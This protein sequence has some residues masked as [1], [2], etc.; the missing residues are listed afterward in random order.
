MPGGNN[1]RAQPTMNHHE[2]YA[3]LSKLPRLGTLDG[4]SCVSVRSSSS[5]LEP[6]EFKQVS[7]SFTQRS[8]KQPRQ[9]VCEPIRKSPSKPECAT[10]VTNHIST[11][12]WDQFDCF[13]SSV[14]CG[15][16]EA[17]FQ[18]KRRLKAKFQYLY[19]DVLRQERAP[20]LHEVYTELY[21]IESD[22][23]KTNKEHEVRQMEILSR[24][25]TTVEMA[26]KCNDIFSSSHRSGKAIHSVLTKGVAGIGKT[27]SV[28]KFVLDWADGR[29][30]QDIE[31]IYPLA[32]RELNLIKE[33]QFSLVELLQYFRMEIPERRDFQDHNVLFIFD[34]LD[35]CRFALDFQNN[36]R[37]LSATM[38]VSL[39]VLLTNLIG[40][41]L[42]P[43]G[44]LWIT[45][46]P[47]AANQI[48]SQFVDLVTEV[49]GFNDLQKEE[50]LKKRISDQSL[51][52]RIIT[53]VKASRCLFI[54]CQIPVFSWITAT[55]LEIMIG[56]SEGGDIPK[57]LTQ[58]YIHF[59]LIQARAKKR[60]FDRKKGLADEDVILK[61]GKLAFEQLEKGNIIFYE[62][63]LRACGI[64]VKE[65]VVYSGVCSQIFKEECALTQ[66]KV[67]CFLHLSI[68]EFLAAL[69]VFVMC[70]VNNLNVLDGKTCFA[71]DR[72]G[73]ALSDLHRSAVDRALKSENGNMDLV[74][75]FL[76]GLSVDSNQTLLQ[77]LLTQVRHSSQSL[78]ASV[79]YI[80]TK[81]EETSSTEKSINL[82]HCLNELNEL[83]LVKDIQHYLSSERFS[84]FSL[85]QWSALV[86]VLLTSAD[87]LNTFE[88]KKYS[89]SDEG[90][91]RLLLVVKASEIALLSNCGLTERCCKALGAALSSDSSSLRELD[92]SSNSVGDVGLRLLAEGLGNAE[93]NL[94]RLR[95]SYCRITPQGCATLTSQLI[96]K[97]S[98]LKELDLSENSL[99]ESGVKILATQLR[100]PQCKIEILRLKDCRVTP[101]GSSALA[102]ALASNPSHLK[103]LD[104]H[105]NN[106][107][108]SGVEQL[109]A[110]V[111][112]PLS[113]LEV[114]WL[115]Y[116]LLTEKCCV[117]L[118]TAFKCC[119]TGLKAV[120]LSGNSIED[121]GVEWLSS[122]L[123]SPHCRLETL[124]LAFCGI[125]EKGASTLASAFAANPAALRELDLS[126]N[127]M[128]D[129]GLKALSR[130]LENFKCRLQT[131]RLRDTGVTQESCIAIASALASNPAHLRELNLSNNNLGDAGIKLLFPA[132][133]DHSSAILKLELRQC[134][135]TKGCCASVA[136]ALSKKSSS[137]RELNLGYNYLQ[138]SG[139]KSLCAALEGPH[140]KLETFSLSNCGLTEESCT[141]LASALRGKHTVLKELDLSENDLKDTDIRQL[142]VLVENPD[143]KLEKITLY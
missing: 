2:E 16:A 122:G 87:K 41:T 97:L 117:A 74:L 17:A 140:C 3:P 109:A 110:V 52:C 14:S 80:K 55:V 35:E 106:P 34:G 60:Y 142:S 82:F 49:R 91:L 102:S 69:Y 19:S 141:I 104:L 135:L 107:G 128:G 99:R 29:A 31:F 127:R 108:D 124:R 83:S 93:S 15:D 61:L 39:D 9:P 63:D 112:D 58:M 48:P 46:R 125:T 32:F 105:W 96:P 44:L 10:A 76:L 89:K 123:Q 70:N 4:P 11:G 72:S 13:P 138:D 5:M 66:S 68:Q 20:S 45:S 130:V 67:Y 75:R 143:H 51:A 86:F 101:N 65:A 81:I 23:S 90:L 132:L 94:E 137:L 95:L 114:L 84:K 62:E 37:V 113:K 30:N 131:L 1:F 57:T 129:S 43:G 54:M 56:S 78:E 22:C 88:L 25:Q 33:E 21:V 121:T 47:A 118:A 42:L 79:D 119:T 103:E 134:N 26:V 71:A 98:R 139:V 136:S 59:L 36:E 133:E 18:H 85:T 24:T 8:C 64:D 7:V 50:F 126:E 12:L 38:Q 100:D 115:S 77:N 92:L 27:V 116:G 6:I 111:E 73:P 40:G 28:Q 53:H 120:D